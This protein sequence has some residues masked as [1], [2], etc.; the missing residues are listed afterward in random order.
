MRLLQIGVICALSGNVF[1]G[2]LTYPIVDTGQNVCYGNTTP[3]TAPAANEA[4]YGQ[5]AQYQGN[6][7][8]YAPG[9]DGL[10]VLDNV[11][12][13]TWAQSPDIT[14]DG[15]IDIDDKLTF[16]EAQNQP[17]LLNAA[18]FGGYTDWRLPSIKELYSLI[19]FSGSDP[20]G[21]QGTN[22]A[23]L[24]PFLD[25]AVFDFGYGD[26]DAGERI[27]DAQFCSTTTYVSTVMN[28]SNAVFG[29]NLAD[30]RIKG[31]D[32]VMPNGTAKE[33]YILCVRGNPGY[34]VNAFI[35]NGDGTISDAATGLMWQAGDSGA[36]LNWQEALAYAEGLTLGGY[37]DWRLPNAKELQSIVD[38]SRSPDTTDSAAIDPR[39]TCST[40]I[41]ED[42]LGDFPF[43]WTGTTHVKYNG[44]GDAA[45][46]VA[47]GEALGWMQQ[48]PMSGNYV[49]LDVHGAGAQRSDP[50]TGDPTDYP[51]G[52]G[53]QGDVIRIFNFVR[54]VRD[55]Q[56]GQP[57]Y[58]SPLSGDLNADCR[59]D[60]QDMAKLSR[61]WKAAYQMTQL[62]RI[63]QNWLES[64]DPIILTNGQ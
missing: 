23:G 43:Y 4:F 57:G 7:P 42:G 59:V 52:H 1:A 36:G 41:A 12:G 29:L 62:N 34:G 45:V 15:L 54:C 13:L 16:A 53:P 6:Q 25:T 22:T 37:D 60:F 40:I 33:F 31:Y 20:S 38:Y 21:Y 61:G 44:M 28:G 3:I 35:D 19:L 46:Y 56:C 48:P 49:L 24:V 47:F 14:G 50:K 64:A 9:P 2:T 8:A 39:F 55:I 26:T 51:Y 11:T 30:G 10:T 17:T 5:D 32:I 58:V 63:A 27:I 18:A